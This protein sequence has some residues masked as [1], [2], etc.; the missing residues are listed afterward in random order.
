MGIFLFQMG[1]L[2]NND[3]YISLFFHA[4]Q[5]LSYKLTLCKMLKLYFLLL[6]K[7]SMT[8]KSRMYH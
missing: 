6:E 5:N 8:E 1:H 2:D 4:I 3:A 7:P